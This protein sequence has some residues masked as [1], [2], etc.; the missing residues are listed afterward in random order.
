MLFD[1]ANIFVFLVAGLVFILLNIAIS[2]I[3]QTRLFSKEKSMAYECGEEPIGDT[4][5]KFNTRFYV[6]ALIFLIFDVEIVYLRALVMLF[7]DAKLGL[8]YDLFLFFD[9]EGKRNDVKAYHVNEYIQEIS[10]EKFT[11][12]DFRTWGGTK[13]AAEKLINFRKKD[14]KKQ[15]KKNITKMVKEVSTKLG[16]TPAVCRGSYIHPRFINDYLRGSFFRLWKETIGEQMYPLSES[17]SHVIRYL[18]NK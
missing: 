16:N 9:E 6:I 5:I 18:E 10:G 14:D 7:N 12:K 17:E 1:F 13:L 4:R 15:R 8:C 3:A 11:A 2:G